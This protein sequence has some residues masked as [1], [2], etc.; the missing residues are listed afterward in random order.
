MPV[1]SVFYG[2]IISLYYFDNKQH[3]LPHVHVRYS[4]MEG[5]FANLVIR[6]F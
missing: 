3:N 2:L 6:Y 4:E 5:V 1:I